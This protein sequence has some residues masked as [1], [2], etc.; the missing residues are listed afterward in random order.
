MTPCH[1]R[2]NDLGEHVNHTG[3]EVGG[4]PVID[5]VFSAEESG[6]C[7]TTTALIQSGGLVLRRA[8]PA[9]DG[10]SHPDRQI[11]G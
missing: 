9:S 8:N 2:L 4:L 5:S 10:G 1:A 3:Y 7:P 11:R 6:F